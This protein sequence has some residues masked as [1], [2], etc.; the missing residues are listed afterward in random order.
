RGAD[1][2]RRQPDPGDLRPHARRPA[3][4]GAGILRHGRGR[5]RGRHRPGHHRVH[6]PNPRVGVTGR[7]Q[8]SEEL[9]GSRARLMNLTNFAWVLIAAPLFSATVLLLAGR[10][11]DKWGHWLGVLAPAVAAVTAIGLLVQLLG[12]PAGERSTDLQ[13][14]SWIPAGDFDVSAGLLIDPLSVTFALL[15]TV[16]GTLIHIYAVGYMAHD[17]DRRRFFAY[18]NLF[19]AAMLILVLADSYAL[20]FLGWEGVGLASYLLIG[21]WYHEPYNAVAG[22]KAFFMNRVGDMG[23]LVAMMLMFATFGSVNFTD[24]LG[25]AGSA[26]EGALTAT[27][28]MLLLGACGE[29]AQIPLQAWLGDAMAGPTPVSALIHAATMVTAGVYLVVR[30]GPVFEGAPT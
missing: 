21:F 10:R 9:T 30:S 11:S 24:V 15:I 25:G 28:L 13:L 19:L 8:P 1:A 17:P 22:N 16:V 12:V 20:L 26:G 5:G 2:E 29:S 6:L 27:S 3:R 4:A 7:R 23:M 18:M 14:Y